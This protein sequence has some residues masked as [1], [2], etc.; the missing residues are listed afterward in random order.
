MQ[1]CTLTTTKSTIQTDFML[2]KLTFLRYDFQEVPENLL[3][4][5]FFFTRIKL[6]SGPDVFILYVELDIDF[7]KTSELLHPKLEVRIRLFECDQSST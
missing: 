2:T 7:L 4:G 3:E 1:T 5:P 6:Y